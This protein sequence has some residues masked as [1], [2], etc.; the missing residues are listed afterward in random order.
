MFRYRRILVPL[1]GSTLAEHA[2]PLAQTLARAMAAE[3]ILLQVVVPLPLPV[4]LGPE[5]GIDRSRREEADRYLAAVAAGLQDG[6]RVRVERLVG[7]AAQQIVHFAQDNEV[8]LIVMSSHGRSGISRWVHGSVTT[9][10]LRQAPCS[11][12]VVHVNDPPPGGALQRVLLPLDGSE[13]AE[14]AIA[15]AAAIARAT[16]AQLVLLAV[17]FSLGEQGPALYRHHLEQIERQEARRQQAYLE[18]VSASLAAPDL[19]VQTALVTGTPAE[20]ILAY[21]EEN[22]IDLIML[23]SHGRSGLERWAFGSVA[24]KVVQGT[25]RAALVVRSGRRHQQADTVER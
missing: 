13:A 19:P 6:T 5:E 2:L 18:N 9:R 25:G 10:V 7:P 8:D 23:A 11:T 24:E 22:A 1:D 14:A 21:A 4:H 12:A 16:G 3:L 20:Q 17:T 15:P